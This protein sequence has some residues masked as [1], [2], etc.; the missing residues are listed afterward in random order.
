[1]VRVRGAGSTNWGLPMSLGADD[2]ADRHPTLAYGPGGALNA[3]WSSRTL[4]SSGVNEAV[5]TSR[6]TDGFNWSTPAPVA[7][8]AAA[9]SIW[10]KLSRGADGRLR[11]AWHDSRSADWRWRV[12]TAKQGGAG[13]AWSSG[14]LLQGRGINTWPALAGNALVFA[15]TRNAA[16]LQ[17]DRTQQIFEVDLP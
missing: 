15:S 7:F 4:H 12:M 16:R 17:R 9:Q 6:T 1:M 3:A 10:P 13:G 2:R 14:Q 5:L 11:I 8:N